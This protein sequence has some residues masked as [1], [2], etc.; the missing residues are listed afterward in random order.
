[1]PE[2]GGET[3]QETLNRA[4][5][6]LSRLREQFRD[7]GYVD[8]FATNDDLALKQCFQNAVVHYTR[9]QQAQQ[10]LEDVF[11]DWHP[12]L[13]PKSIKIL[14]FLISRAPTALNTLLAYVREALENPFPSLTTLHLAEH[15]MLIDEYRGEFNNE[16]IHLLQLSSSPYIHLLSRLINTHPPLEN[17]YI[18]I[19]NDCLQANGSLMHQVRRMI[20]AEKRGVHSLAYNHLLN[21][22][23]EWC[24]CHQQPTISRNHYDRNRVVEWL[25]SIASHSEIVFVITMFDRRNRNTISHPGDESIEVTPVDKA[26]YEEHLERLNLF[27]PNFLRRIP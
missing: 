23:Q 12:A 6:V 16:V 18:N 17:R 14:V 5:L 15:L 3:P 7:R 9:S 20:I 25:E 24:F 22:L 4:V 2:E 13:M 27:L 1:L 8:R 11:Q 10:Q 19:E 21:T 26:E